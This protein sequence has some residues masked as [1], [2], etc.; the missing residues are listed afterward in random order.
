MLGSECPKCHQLNCVRTRYDHVCGDHTYWCM[1][2][3][4]EWTAWNISFES[5]VKSVVPA[6]KIVMRRLL[7]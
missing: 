7:K 1:A 2:C 6:F 3:G 5:G 4:N